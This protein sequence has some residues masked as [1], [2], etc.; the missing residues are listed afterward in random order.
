MLWR[1][2]G[3]VVCFNMVSCDVYVFI[4]YLLFLF[5]FGCVFMCLGTIVFMDFEKYWNYCCFLIKMLHI[6]YCIC[7]IFVI[8]WWILFVFIGTNC[9]Q[10]K[11]K[12]TPIYVQVVIDIHYKMFWRLYVKHT[13]V[14][15]D[16][17]EWIQVYTLWSYGRRWIFYCY[18]YYRGSFCD[19]LFTLS[20]CWVFHSSVKLWSDILEQ[21]LKRWLV[22]CLEGWSYHN[23]WTY[24]SIHVWSLFCYYSF[25]SKFHPTIIFVGT[26]NN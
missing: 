8:S 7:C 5:V 4:T 6:V 14:L 11:K 3:I 26:W 15:W 19:H 17:R 12:N 2:K 9:W 1:L 22:I 13:W 21:I 20:K 16:C 24:W 23:D 10:S 25:H 18:L